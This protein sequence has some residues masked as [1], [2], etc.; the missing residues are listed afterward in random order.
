MDAEIT[1]KQSSDIVDVVFTKGE[2]ISI[3]PVYA[4]FYPQAETQILNKNNIIEKEQEIMNTKEV[5]EE[6]IVAKDVKEEIAA[7][8]ETPVAETKEEDTNMSIKNVKLE[9]VSTLETREVEQVKI[10]NLQQARNVLSNETFNT[11]QAK[12]AQA[13]E[14]ISLESIHSK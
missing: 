2:L 5:K 3:D 4:G 8:N 12:A 13:S 7:T 1:E 10:D 9:E 11:L 14:K 6:T